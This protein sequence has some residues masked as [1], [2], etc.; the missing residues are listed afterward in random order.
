MKD[1]GGVDIGAPFRWPD[2]FY[3]LCITLYNGNL[4]Y[5]ICYR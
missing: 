3:F 4:S 2:D 5:A 1:I